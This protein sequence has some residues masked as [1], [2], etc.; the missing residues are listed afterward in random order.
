[1]PPK[2][3]IA[4]AEAAFIAGLTDR[5]MHRIV[6][7]RLVPQSLFERQGSQRRFTLLAAGL[8]KFYFGTEDVLLAGARRWVLDE[9][10]A[11]VQRLEADMGV[12]ALSR[13]D[14]VD[15]KVARKALVI[16]VL[17][18]LQE[19]LARADEV[20]RASAL[21]TADPELMGGAAVFAGTRVPVEIVL[22]SLAAGVGMDRLKASYP[23][24]TEAHVRAAAIHN[25]VHPRRGR[26]RRRWSDANPEATPVAT[27]VVRRTF[28]A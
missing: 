18:Y 16:D 8:A 25:E 21:V 15:W 19:T 2:H 10:T 4:T 28:A 3:F 13:L 23:F 26:P 1:M 24:L 11:R 12:L 27:R 22:G 7:E 6:D 17:P 5:Q 14:A 9:I 20:A